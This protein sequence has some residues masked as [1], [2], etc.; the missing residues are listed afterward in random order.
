[1]EFW[2]RKAAGP[3][4]AVELLTRMGVGR[5]GRESE[6]GD[7][8]DGTKLHGESSKKVTLTPL[9]KPAWPA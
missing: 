6:N 4:S 1:V 2:P 9:R 5:D 7:C 3:V 8:G